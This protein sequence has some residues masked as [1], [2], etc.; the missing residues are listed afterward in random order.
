MVDEVDQCCVNLNIFCCFDVLFCGVLKTTAVRD[1]RW[2]L[3]RPERVEVQADQRGKSKGEV[4]KAKGGRGCAAGRGD[5]VFAV[6]L[7]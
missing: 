5:S 7:T 3:L 4:E 1:G 2:G 6:R